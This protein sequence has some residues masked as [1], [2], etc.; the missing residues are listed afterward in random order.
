MWGLIKE[1]LSKINI[2]TKQELKDKIIEIKE[3]IEGSFIE[4]FIYSMKKRLKEVMK[5]TAKNGCAS[6]N[7]SFVCRFC[8]SNNPFH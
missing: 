5:T 7:M 6:G 3:E 2:K 1:K 4:N 8:Y